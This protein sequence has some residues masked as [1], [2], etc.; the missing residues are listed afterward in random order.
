MDEDYVEPY[1][2]ALKVSD[3]ERAH[4]KWL[5]GEQLSEKDLQALAALRSFS[6]AIGASTQ[7]RVY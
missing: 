7:P 5:R 1:F 4:A 2:N 3:L 6:L